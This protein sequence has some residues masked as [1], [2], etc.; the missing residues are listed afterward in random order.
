MKRTTIKR[1]L[2]IFL[3]LGALFFIA[4]GIQAAWK[5]QQNVMGQLQI[6][7]TPAA[8]VFINNVNKGST[9]YDVQIPAGDY[10]IKLIPDQEATVTASWQGK[11]NVGRGTLTYI[12]R[13]LGMGDVDSAGEVFTLSK[14]TGKYQKK[15]GEVV[16]DSEPIGTLV[17]LDGDEKGIAP[18]TL[19]DVPE[20]S[21]EL[22]QYLPGFYRRTQAIN[23]VD[24]Y[25]LT[26]QIKL[27]IDPT[28]LQNKPK[29]LPSKEATDEASLEATESATLVPTSTV[30]AFDTVTIVGTPNGF[31][32][33]RK[34]PNINA[35]E[36]AQVDEGDRYSLLEEVGG[37][38][39]IP[40]SETEEGWISA[41]F[42]TKE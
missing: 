35:E 12:S 19:A 10:T 42:T 17:S 5:S 8:N 38:I 9:P 36:V 18:L 7:S 41:Q 22:S 6:F 1:K 23:V 25:R 40:Y 29:K 3:V 24:G 34:E 28:S 27:A 39:R 15:T 31:L 21:H 26:A 32:R 2:L 14:I 16:I 20:G 37:W 13:E 4:I 30:S 11:V 33:V